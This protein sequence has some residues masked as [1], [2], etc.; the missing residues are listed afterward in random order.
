[1]DR[2]AGRLADREQ[3]EDDLFRIAGI[4]GHDLAVEI[5]RDAAH[6]VMHGR[7]DGQRLAGEVDPGEDF[8][9]FGDA[10]QAFGQ[11]RR[12]DMVEMEVDVVAIH[13][14]AAALAHFERHRARHD[15]AA[16][17]ILRA[18]RI[19]LHEALAFG[20]GQVAALA[21]R[22][23]GDQHART[24]DPGR[25][26]L[27]EFH[28]LQRQ[29]GAQHHAAAVARAGVRAGGGV[30]AAAIA[31]GRQHHALRAEPV[32][33]PVIEAHGDHADALL[34]V[35]AVLHDQVDGEIF[36]EEGRVVFEALLIER[37]EH[38]VAGAIGRRAGAL[39]GRAFAHILHMATERAL[40]DRPVIIAAERHAGMFEFV[41]RMRRLAHHVFD[42]VLIAEPVGPLDRIVHV[43]RPVIGRIVAERGGDPALRRDRVR[44]G[45]EDLGNIRRFQSG[46]GRAHRRAQAGSP[47]ADHDDVVGMV[48]DIIGAS[49]NFENVGCGHQA[50]PAKTM[51]AM[52]SSPKAAPANTA[53][54]RR[55]VSAKRL[56]ALST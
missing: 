51:R 34:A 56:P 2:N 41:N 13:A 49:A 5:T 10:R 9:A 1:M 37:M 20:I 55:A 16:G 26:E 53:I 14:H 18:G 48:D 21:A 39:H 50:A 12:I 52:L 31:A 19:A 47:R 28:V 8:A 32:D 44:A 4:A 35:G 43:P 24:V 3:A 33:R 40:I 46:F 45:W 22:A 38:G 7:G 36:D 15:I 42:R 17:K 30:I 29:S 11:D 54:L 6:I 23:L 27:D 25:V